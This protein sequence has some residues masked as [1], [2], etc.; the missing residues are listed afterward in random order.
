MMEKLRNSKGSKNQQPADDDAGAGGDENRAAGGAAIEAADGSNDDGISA[1]FTPA[2][3]GF[4]NIAWGVAYKI[5]TV[6]VLLTILG[7]LTGTPRD[8]HNIAVLL[9]ERP[10]DEDIA[11]VE[12]VINNLGLTIRPNR[13]ARFPPEGL[14]RIWLRQQINRN[15]AI[16]VPIITEN[17]QTFNVNAIMNNFNRVMETLD[18]GP[19]L[20]IADAEDADI[21]EILR[22]TRHS[23]RVTRRPFAAHGEVEQPILNYDLRE[24]KPTCYA[25]YSDDEDDSDAKLESD[26]GSGAYGNADSGEA[27]DKIDNSKKVNKRSGRRMRAHSRIRNPIRGS[28]TA[29]APRRLTLQEQQRMFLLDIPVLRSGILFMN[30]DVIP[31]RLPLDSE[32]KSDKPDPIWELGC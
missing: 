14:H 10:S 22:S 25:S 4:F 3:N 11:N 28:A 17:Q 8:H 18:E 12:A 27:S 21:E 16:L 32:D 31:M 9:S 7:L 6:I 13:A 1:P 24:R 23:V 26:S 2:R 19:R 20:D 29:R 15:Q 5:M 30:L